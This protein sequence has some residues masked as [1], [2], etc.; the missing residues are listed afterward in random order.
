[1]AT[2]PNA[3]AIA[4]DPTWLAHRYDSVGDA[5]HF[6]QVAREGHRA[7]TFLTDE[8][9]PG[10]KAPKSIRRE[11]A[12][13]GAGSVA[14]IHFIFHSAYC[15]STLLARAFDVEGIAM[16]LKEPVILND[17]SGW[18]RRGGVPADLAR[19]LDGAMTLLARPFAPDEAIVVKPSN[20]VNGL[21]ASMLA[22]RPHA[23][24]VLLYAPLRLYLASIAK[25]GMWGR[26]WVR[27]LYVKLTQDGLTDY[28]FTP[29]EVLSQTD[30]QI[31]AIG[32]LSQHRLFQV[33]VD[34]YGPDRV[35]T[36]DSEML[37]ARPA[38][39]IAALARLYR[40]PL[41]ARAIA[42]I[43]GGDAFTT[44]SKGTGS[45]SRAERVA[46]QQ[47]AASVHAEEVDKVTLWAEAV[48][49]S[50]RQPLLLGAPLLG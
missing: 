9:L 40:L 19:G 2:D 48:A 37:L 32:W 36:L 27:D 18:R 47:D 44:H 30:L 3:A 13:A 10:A 16:G 26:L 21:A 35:R 43:V 39:A 29:E 28:G 50:A 5:I 12:L 38:D 14:P 34:R 7:A 15:C 46:E 17:I 24:A 31:A 25:K 23:G 4:R 11:T 42:R 22:M 49:A 20:V 1:M 6:I 8:Y 45:F 33:L 41:D